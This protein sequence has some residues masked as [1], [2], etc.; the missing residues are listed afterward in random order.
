MGSEELE[1]RNKNLIRKLYERLNNQDETLFDLLSEDFRFHTASETLRTKEE[2][3][4]QVLGEYVAFP[5]FHVEIKR[6]TA[7]GNV[8]VAEYDWTATHEGEFLGIPASF[9]EVMVPFIDIFDI[10]NGKV[11]LWR[12]MFNWPYWER[13]MT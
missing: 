4:A 10:E 7:E 6:L 1:G 9:K 3:R 12:D 11:K 2:F 8:V 13:Q 5:D